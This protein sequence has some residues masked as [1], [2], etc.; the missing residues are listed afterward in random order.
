MGKAAWG[1]V[2]A[3]CFF[4]AAGGPSGAQPFGTLSLT[5][6]SEVRI[7]VAAGDGVDAESAQV[8]VE[9]RLQKAGI[10]VKSE[11]SS[12]LQVS[13][14]AGR[15]LLM[16][17]LTL[18]QGVCLEREPVIT[19]VVPTWVLGRAVRLA[20]G[21]SVDGEVATSLETLLQEFVREWELANRLP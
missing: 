1:W 2:L 10:V 5:R 14:K 16:T 11:A 8:L 9:E 6:L 4:V 13:I 12:L 20:E 15:A 7:E 18:S 21:G 17:D 19:A 3:I